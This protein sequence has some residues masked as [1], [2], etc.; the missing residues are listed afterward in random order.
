[1]LILE[2]PKSAIYCLAFTP[3]GER[4]AVGSKDGLVEEWTMEGCLGPILNTAKLSY[5]TLPPVHAIRYDSTGNKLA[6][7]GAIGWFGA[8]A[9][10]ENFPRKFISFD[11]T[12]DRPVTSIEFL[13]DT[14]V[15]VGHGSRTS[16]AGGSFELWDWK[17]ELDVRPPPFRE[18]LGVRAVATHPNTQTVAWSTGHKKLTI[19]NISKPDQTHIPLTHTSTSIGFHPDGTTLAAAIE[20]GFGAFDIVKRQQRYLITGHKGRVTSIAYSPDGK[21]IATGS[22]DQTVRLWDAASG[23]EIACYDF[24]IGR[25]YCLTYAP[26]GLRIAAAGE[27]GTI[28]IWDAE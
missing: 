28:A 11:V 25:I 13:S 26:D 6:I 24:G 18:A 20:W 27:K 19:W 9:T 5:D 1:M 10:N 12:I 3:D 15:C 2:G 23:K 16:D 8:V 14:L 7:G 4:F 21:T 17:D 22:W